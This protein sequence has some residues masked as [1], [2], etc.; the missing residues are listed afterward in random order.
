M[1]YGDVRMAL[2]SQR[3][4]TRCGT[5][6]R[7]GYCAERATS[8]AQVGP[9]D[10]LQNEQKNIPTDVKVG[11]LLGATWLCAAGVGGGA[12]GSVGGP[13]APAGGLPG[14]AQQ[15]GLQVHRV[16]KLRVA[17]VRLAGHWHLAVRPPCPCARQAWRWLHPLHRWVPQLADAKDVMARMA[18]QSGTRYPVLTPN[19]QAGRGGRGGGPGLAHAHAHAVL[20]TC[21]PR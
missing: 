3:R 21:R 11:G 9:R 18:R 12:A 13:S 20:R 7:K 2:R 6:R 10:G 8:A 14:Q 15:R 4:A 17:Q 1:R 5:R 16:H 19:M